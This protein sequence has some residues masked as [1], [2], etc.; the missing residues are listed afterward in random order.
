[1]VSNALREA[2]LSAALQSWADG[3]GV[4]FEVARHGT[5]AATAARYA[6]RTRCW[7]G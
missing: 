2:R 7:V 5:A 1:M 6:S 3:S 4:C